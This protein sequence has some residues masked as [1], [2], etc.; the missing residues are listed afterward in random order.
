MGPTL[1]AFS[2]QIPDL[3]GTNT[4]EYL[5]A[6]PSS[7]KWVLES[8]SFTPETALATDASN[9]GT[10]AANKGAGGSAIGSLTTNSSG[11][12][13]NVKGTRRDFSLTSSLVN[14]DSATTTETLEIAVTKA[15]TGGTIGGTISGLW[16]RARD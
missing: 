9:Y 3:T 6:P 13:A 11:G 16:R 2:V 1:L 5:I 14:F 4:N 10:I 7:G 8:L 15:G 12:A